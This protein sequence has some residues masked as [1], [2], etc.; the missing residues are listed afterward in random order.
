MGVLILLLVVSVV[1]FNIGMIIRLFTCVFPRRKEC[2]KKCPLYFACGIWQETYHGR[3][4]TEE[5]AEE[6]LKIIQERKNENR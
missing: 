2:S 1:L 4:L 3:K 5:E 6:L